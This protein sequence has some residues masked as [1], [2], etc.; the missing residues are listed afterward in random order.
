MGAVLFVW[1][2]IRSV[3][4]NYPRKS[5]SVGKQ[6]LRRRGSFGDLYQNLGIVLQGEPPY[7]IAQ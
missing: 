1:K 7:A 5:L 3:A 6:A 2:R 4:T